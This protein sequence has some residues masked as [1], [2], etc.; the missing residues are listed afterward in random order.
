[1]SQPALVPSAIS[2][3]TL[4]ISSGVGGAVLGSWVKRL[5]NRIVA[6]PGLYPA[7]RAWRALLLERRSGPGRFDIRSEVFFRELQR[8][9]LVQ[10]GAPVGLELRREAAHL[11]HGDEALD[12]H[13]RL[14]GV[15]VLL[16][17]DEGDDGQAVEERLG[18]ERVGVAH[19]VA[20]MNELTLGPDGVGIG[21][22]L[23]VEDDLDQ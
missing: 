19:L 14:H 5:M 22:Q 23:G 20:V 9:S 18:E 13:H 16:A 2:L 10:I 17:R 12:V 4:A 7:V 3:S 1:M 11:E 21:L 15:G 6:P 8:A